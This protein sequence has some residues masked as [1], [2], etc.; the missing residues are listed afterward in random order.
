[1]KQ[2]LVILPVT[3]VM[4]YLVV[5]LG[6]VRVM[7]VGAVV[8]LYVAEEVNSTINVYTST[9]CICSLSSTY[10]LITL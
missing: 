5:I 7:E 2:I 8:R 1:M 6:P 3:L 4:S 10:I 9:L